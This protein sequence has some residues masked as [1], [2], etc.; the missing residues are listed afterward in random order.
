MT[1]ALFRRAESQQAGADLAFGH[2][3]RGN[4]AFFLRPVS[5]A[6]F[7]GPNHA[8]PASRAKLSGKLGIAAAYPAINDGNEPASFHLG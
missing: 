7:L 5:A 4:K 2:P 8:Q 1:L 3:M 6:I